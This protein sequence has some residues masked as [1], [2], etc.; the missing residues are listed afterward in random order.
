MGGAHR[1]SHG[2]DIAH[3]I[4]RTRARSIAERLGAVARSYFGGL[5]FFQTCV[6]GGLSAFQLGFKGL[7]LSDLLR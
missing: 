2:Y 4:M 1:L 5:G 7:F 6:D 3:E